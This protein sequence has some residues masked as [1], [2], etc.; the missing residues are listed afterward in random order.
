MKLFQH[1]HFPHVTGNRVSLRQILDTDLDDLMEISFYDAVQAQTVQQAAEMQ[2]K[3]NQDYLDGN[4]IHWGIVDHSTN[5]IV[6]TC[7]YYRGLDRGEGELGC[8]LLSKYYGQGYMTEGMSLAIEFGLNH[9]GLKRIWA[10]TSQ[11]NGPAIKLLE[12]LN[13]VKIADTAEDEI[14]YELR[15]VIN[16]YHSMK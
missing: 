11:Q 10:A 7:G 8:V 13:F 2:A 1:D 15:P 9:M 4:S 16:Q 12:R 14:E 3:I 5:T 6:G